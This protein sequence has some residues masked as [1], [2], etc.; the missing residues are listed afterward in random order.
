MTTWA[1]WGMRSRRGPGGKGSA[2]WKGVVAVMAMGGFMGVA[3]GAAGLQVQGHLDFGVAVRP[4]DAGPHDDRILDAETR[5][6]LERQWYG[7]R[8]EMLDLRFLGI[9]E[10]RGD[11]RVEIRQASLFI[12]LGRHLEITAGRQVLSWGPAQ[13]E[14][15]N[16]RFAKDFDSFFLGRDLE[17]LKAPNDALR[18]RSFLG[19]WTLDA[20]V[21]PVFQGDR[22]PNPERFPV[23]N[24]V[25][26]EAEANPAFQADLPRESLSDGEVHLRL[27]RRLGR[28]EGA[29]YAYRGF[30]GTPEGIREVDG[31][32]TS[33]HPAMAAVGFSLRGPFL[34]GLGWLEA[35]FEDIR[36]EDAGTSPRLP[37][38]RWLALAGTRWSPSPTRSWMVQASA[39]GQAGATELRETLRALD[40]GHPAVEGIHYRLHG[41]VTQSL[42]AER[43]EVGGRVLWG[44]TEEDAHW[45]VRLAYELSDDLA[46]EVR[47]HGFAGTH[48]AERFGLLRDHDLFALRLRYHL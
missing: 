18:V 44:V 22:L 16:D 35:A 42:L 6:L 41:S 8:G 17:Y 25:S 48:P 29:L 5:L 32:P 40:P 37:P 4:S 10:F 24:P 28:W 1:R 26:G 9:Q 15:V 30:T 2:A 27:D 13:F 33:F 45:R 23:P 39:V 46:F 14:F 38:D 47:Y 36:E 21:M 19:R 34:A 7:D 12:P 3:D 11:G 43:M 20:A 31:A